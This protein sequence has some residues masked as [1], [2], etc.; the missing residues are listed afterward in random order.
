MIKFHAG[1]IVPETG[2]YRIVDKKGK[3][4]E[5]TLLSKGQRFPPKKKEKCYYVLDF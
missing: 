1:D 4:L 5:Q 2:F 3:T